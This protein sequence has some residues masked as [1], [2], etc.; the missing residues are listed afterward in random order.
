[1]K[2][3]VPFS[4]GTGVVLLGVALVAGGVAQV[5]TGPGWEIPVAAATNLDLFG[6]ISIVLYGVGIICYLRGNRFRSLSP[7]SRKIFWILLFFG[8][9]ITASSYLL[10]PGQWQITHRHLS[11][12]LRKSSVPI[13]VICG[14]VWMLLTARTRRTPSLDA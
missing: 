4:I 11:A 13:G 7:S 10:D 2:E 3:E 9:L 1:M 14:I 8:L 5:Q 6:L 12:A